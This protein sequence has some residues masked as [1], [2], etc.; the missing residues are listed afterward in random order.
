M[1]LIAFRECWQLIEI[2]LWDCIK[3]A[4]SYIYK[5]SHLEINELHLLPLKSQA[6]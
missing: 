2:Q 4:D 1:I 6:I 5:M 3:T